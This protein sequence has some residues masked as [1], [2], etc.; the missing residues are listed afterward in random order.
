MISIR[1]EELGKSYNIYNKPIDSLKEWL[2]RRSYHET[3]WALRDV[4]FNLPYGASLGVV[5]ENGAGKTTLL[6]LLAGTIAPTCG[7]IERNGRVSAILELGSGFHPDL[8][9]RENIRLG[10]AVIGLSPSETEQ[11][12]PEIIAFSELENFIE[13][14]VKT[15]STG[16]Y[17]RL[18]FSVATSVDPDI[19]VVDEALSVG[20]Q[21]F[22]KKCMDRMIEFREQG[23]TLIFCSHILY[24]IQQVCDQCLWL[25]K[26]RPEMLGPTIEVTEGYQDYERSLDAEDTPETANTTELSEKRFGGDTC[27]REV[28]LGGDCRDG[29]IETGGTFMVRVVVRLAPTVRTEGAH[30]AVIITRNDGMQCYGVSTEM[31]GVELY[32]LSGRG[33]FGINFVVEELLLL[34]G[35]YSLEIALLDD[36]GVHVYD[37]WKGVAPF[38]IHQNTKEIGVA[39]LRHRWERP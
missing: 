33:E 31:D 29:I 17:A 23:K 36:N 18:A 2:F 26:G 14:P 30:L 27:L 24:F 21:H 19:F 15:Y 7:R 10:C 32:S 25:R 34:T 22:K 37:F 38:K 11:R 39:R 13:R 3:F 12:L 4:N 35:Q 16:M 9:G 5:G 20:D 28:T 8:S 1:V 6:K